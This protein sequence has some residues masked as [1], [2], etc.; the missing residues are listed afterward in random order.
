[1]STSVTTS[2]SPSTLKMVN[3]PVRLSLLESNTKALDEGLELLA[4]IEQA[5]FTRSF[6]PAFESTIGAH[7]RHVLE[8]YRCFINQQAHAQFCYDKRERDQ[9]LEVEL[10]YAVKEIHELRSA[11][12]NLNDK[13]F[14]LEYTIVDQQLASSNGDQ[15][16]S[17]PTT[18]QREL[19]FLQS[20]T[21]HHYAMIGAMV[22]LLGMPT[23]SNFGVAFATRKHEQEVSARALIGEVNKLEEG[24]K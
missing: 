5:H 7:F 3:D 1:M 13:V 22:R 10:N 14:E 15:T 11:I 23:E 20:H 19:L 24:H 2:P 17:I 9:R 16:T 4:T 21:V 6:K 12:T 8:H 18:L